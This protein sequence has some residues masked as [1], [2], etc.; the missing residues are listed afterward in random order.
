MFVAEKNSASDLAYNPKKKPTKTFYPVSGEEQFLYLSFFCFQNVKK[1]S[2]LRSGVRSSF[3]KSNQVFHNRSQ[4]SVFLSK[5]VVKL[6]IDFIE[7]GI[8]GHGFRSWL[9]NLC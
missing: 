7:S 8:N 3:P 2:V 6:P 1:F 5:G 9:G 4:G